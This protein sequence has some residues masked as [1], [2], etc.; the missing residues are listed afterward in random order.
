MPPRELVE[1]RILAKDYKDIEP[2]EVLVASRN[3]NH[4]IWA[5]ESLCTRLERLGQNN[6][7]Y[8]VRGPDG[9]TLLHI[10]AAISTTNWLHGN[11]QCQAV[12]SD[13]IIRG[14]RTG[15]A[16]HA[17]D[18]HGCTPFTALFLAPHSQTNKF[19][20]ATSFL[21]ILAEGGVD[22][23][24]FGERESD[25]MRKC[26]YYQ[27]PMKSGFRFG[28]NPEDWHLWKTNRRN[29]L[30]EGFWRMTEGSEQAIP[31]AWVDEVQDATPGELVALETWYRGS[32]IKRRTLRRLQH[33]LTVQNPDFEKTVAYE[34][35][36]RAVMALAE[37]RKTYERFNHERE[38]YR[39]D[40]MR[41]AKRL[42]ISR[43]D[44]YRH[45]GTFW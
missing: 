18:V 29:F 7:L 1:V 30:V 5:E 21:E 8:S 33:V 22:L 43:G 37:S 10:L 41:A 12:L 28:P 31:G 34:D 32:G 24:A 13:I 40:I 44:W 42:V 20:G 38:S 15:A 16:I 45:G 3:G 6:E 9:V 25:L 39:Y 36:S 2:V 19:I 35:L 27:S 17:R 14:I 26:E 11:I 4:N 23:V